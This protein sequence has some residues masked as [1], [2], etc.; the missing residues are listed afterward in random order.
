MSRTNDELVGRMYT[1]FEQGDI[2]SVLQALDDHVVW[3]EAEHSP[4]D[5]GRPLVGRDEVLERIFGR[6]AAEWDAF[7]VTPFV[8]HTCGDV[9]IVEGRYSGRNL[10]TDR[11]LDAAFCH[12]WTLAHGRVVSFRQYADTAHMRS[13][14]GVDALGR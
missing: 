11:M 5:E 14:A 2:I 4:Y 12:I 8:F 13:T 6:L 10:A 9:V 3:R 7:T 1:D